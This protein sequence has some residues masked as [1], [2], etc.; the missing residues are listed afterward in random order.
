MTRHTR[1]DQGSALIVVIV[2]ATVAIVGALGFVLWRN[3]NSENTATQEAT[4]TGTVEQVNEDQIV[5]SDWG[6]SFEAPAT[7]SEVTY[8]KE[9]SDGTDYYGFSTKRVEAIEPAC[10]DPELANTTWL[11]SLFR[12]KVSQ[13]G[14]IGTIVLNDNVAIDGFYYYTTGARSSCSTKSPEIQSEDLAAIDS[15]LRTI[16]A[17]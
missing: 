16:K 8:H 12:S 7:E 5:L 1:D 17:E 4:V 13:E 15:M 10:A 3:M 2:I 9:S 14:T 6:V 11:A